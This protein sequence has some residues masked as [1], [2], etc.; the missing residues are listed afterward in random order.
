MTI[1]FVVPGR[2][3]PMA[4]PR[5]T[6]RGTYT[7]RECREYK[8]L[9]ACIAKSVMNGN[10]YRMFESGPLECRVRFIFPL[11]KTR[12]NPWAT[13]RP[14]LDNLYKAVTD[15]M[16]G[17]VYKDDAQIVRAS[18]EKAYEING[19]GRAEIWVREIV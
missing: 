9:V 14:D 1:E 16:N 18:I 4:R 17:I 7:P 12:K 19:D 6:A 5:V 11:P 15:A 10:D 8:K 13:S 3:V 2:P